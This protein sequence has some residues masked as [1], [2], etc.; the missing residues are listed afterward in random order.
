[1]PSSG[2]TLEILSEERDTFRRRD[3]I[4]AEPSMS[5]TSRLGTAMSPLLGLRGKASDEV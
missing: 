4:F 1:M 3:T 5:P 2:L